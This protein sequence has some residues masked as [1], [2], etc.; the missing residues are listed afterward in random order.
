[1]NKLTKEDL[2]SIETEFIRSKHF[3]NLPIHTPRASEASDVQFMQ[4]K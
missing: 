4:P 1:M 3:S 2:K